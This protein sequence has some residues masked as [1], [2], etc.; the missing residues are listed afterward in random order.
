MTPSGP[1]ATPGIALKIL[2]GDNI[3]TGDGDRPRTA[4]AEELTR[5]I[6]V[7]AKD[8]AD[9]SD[10]QLLAKLPSIAVIARST[11][12]IKMRVESNC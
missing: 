7:E 1:A 9:M 10:E 3:V 11:P 12:I 6:A 4:P 5:G 8:I 2:T